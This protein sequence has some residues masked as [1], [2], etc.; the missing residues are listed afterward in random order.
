MKRNFRS[1]FVAS[2]LSGIL[3]VSVAG[4]ESLERKFVRKSKTPKPPPT[5]IISFQD[6]SQAMTPLD[7]Y[8]KHYMIFDYWNDD[9]IQALQSPPLN[10]KRY[11]QASSESLAELQTMQQLVNDE[12]APRF[13]PLIAAR[14]KLDRELQT[15]NV[16][17]G[18]T[19]FLCR[20]LETQKRQLHRDFFWRDVQD[21]LKPQP[22]PNG[23][24][25]APAP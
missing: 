10:P 9:L 22:S 20:T 13:D 8:R 24:A 5:P 18:Q 4:C 23:Q 1:S 16:G 3:L 14:V 15:G 2:L 6:Y 25:N 17:E 21:R 7:R 11:K 12:F 19:S